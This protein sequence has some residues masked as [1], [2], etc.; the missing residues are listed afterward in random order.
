MVDVNLSNENQVQNI[1]IPDSRINR[2]NEVQRK[3]SMR[4]ANSVMIL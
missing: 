1:E 2:R 3:D 4:G